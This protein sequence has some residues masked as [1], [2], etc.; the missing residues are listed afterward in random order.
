MKK[1]SL[2][3]FI[4][5][6]LL[7]ATTPAW[8]RVETL[9]A[10]DTVQAEEAEHA[11]QPAPDRPINDDVPARNSEEAQIQIQDQTPQQAQDAM[12]QAQQRAA[13]AHGRRLRNR[14]NFYYQ[15]LSQI[16]DKIENRFNLL[17]RQGVDMTEAR[18]GFNQAM[19]R[20]EAAMEKADQAIAQ[21]ETI[22]PEDFDDQQQIA[23][24]A[25]D[26]ALEARDDF[27]AARDAMKQAVETAITQI[28]DN[29]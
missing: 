18:A 12:Q 5:L 28:A 7:A 11:R 24:T 2:L 3:I 21:F 15:R 4:G 26:L 16:G 6:I 20:L 8:A 29:N 22:E 9:P 27:I 13:A 14:Y 25:R 19:Q 23:L 10:D 17:E 1:T